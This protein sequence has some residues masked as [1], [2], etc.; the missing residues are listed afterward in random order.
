MTN[1]VIYPANLNVMGRMSFPL[2]SEENIEQLKEWRTRRNVAK[3]KYDDRVG[4]ALYITQAQEDRVCANLLDVYLPFASTLQAETNKEKGIDPKLVAKLVKLVE[5]RDWTEKNLPIRELN[6]KD[7]ENLEKN[8]IDNIVS[9][10]S[11]AGPQTQPIKRKAIVNRDGDQIVVGLD[12][13]QVREK[14]ESIERADSD[15]LWWGSL[16]PFKTQVRFNAYDAAKYGVSAYVNTAYLF[17][18]QELITFSGSDAAILE[19]GDDWED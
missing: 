6:D 1:K 10:I 11:V 5:A 17:A 15:A 3:P 13:E 2:Y 4:F 12:D 9:K 16:W 7:V 8:G 19:D 18:D 14:L